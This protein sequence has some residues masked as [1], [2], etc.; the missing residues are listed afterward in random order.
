[1]SFEV[2]QGPGYGHHPKA[3]FYGGL[4]ATA[5][6]AGMF[7]WGDTLTYRL[8][9]NRNSVF[10]GGL[11]ASLLRL[12]GVIF[13]ESSGGGIWQKTQSLNSG[14]VP[15]LKYKIGQRG[16]RYLTQPAL[17]QVFHGYYGLSPTMAAGSSAVIVAVSESTVLLPIEILKVKAQ[18]YPSQYA[19]LRLWQMFAR[20]PIR[21]CYRSLGVT[22]L[23]AGT[24]FFTFFAGREKAQEYFQQRGYEEA[25]ARLYGA[26][27]GI[28][29][30]TLVDSP[31][32]VIRTRMLAEEYGQK[33]TG[34]EVTVKLVK[35]EGLSVL[36]RAVWV[37]LPINV[38]R[39][40]VCYELVGVFAGLF[41]KYCFS[42]DPTQF[43][44]HTLK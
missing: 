26:C 8:M 12:N 18:L 38:L 30:S 36:G 6:S 31:L 10:S 24:S 25:Q 44:E 39:L 20:F 22:N 5:T 11:K 29:M 14:L 35:K 32:D 19:G 9:A 42:K 37:K 27:A 34:R 21:D 1:M 33:S 16:F 13:Q 4:T 3:K 28:V 41:Q 43:D 7:H 40:G 17:Q 2:D 15:A 23:K